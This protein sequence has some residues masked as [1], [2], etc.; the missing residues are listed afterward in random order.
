[1]QVDLERLP[2]NETKVYTQQKKWIAH[3]AQQN[4]KAMNKVLT[5]MNPK[6]GNAPSS[7]TVPEFTRSGTL[8]GNRT[9][10][11]S[12]QSPGNNSRSIWSKKFFFGGVGPRGGA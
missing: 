8:F 7:S 6:I 3:N 11:M 9:N 5:E 4:Q 10:F 1:M 2:S 12:H